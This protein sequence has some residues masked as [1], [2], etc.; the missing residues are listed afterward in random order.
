MRKSKIE[1]MEKS[2][3]W[4]CIFI[5]LALLRQFTFHLIII[6]IWMHIYQIGI[7]P[8]FGA[9]GYFLL[10]GSKII[11]LN[12]VRKGLINHQIGGKFVSPQNV[13]QRHSNDDYINYQTV[14][15]NMSLT[16]RSFEMD[17]P[18]VRPTTV[19]HSNIAGP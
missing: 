10:F 12:F 14:E 18:L 16:P 7:S 13:G 8:Y 17:A 9:L 1:S 11:G 3:P 6:T 4:Y 5:T 19:F 15:T 2:K